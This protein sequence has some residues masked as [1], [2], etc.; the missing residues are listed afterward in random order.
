[1]DD[2]P[3]PAVPAKRPRHSLGSRPFARPHTNQPRPQSQNTPPHYLQKPASQSIYQAGTHHPPPL[4]AHP[5]PAPRPNYRPLA[6]APQQSSRPPASSTVS[7]PATVTPGSPHIDAEGMTVRPQIDSRLGI[8][9]SFDVEQPDRHPPEMLS[10]QST[11]Q[12]STQ[13]TKRLLNPA[14]SKTSNSQQ[15]RNR[16]S[17]SF[18]RDRGPT[19]ADDDNDSVESKYSLTHLGQEIFLLRPTITRM[20]QYVRSESQKL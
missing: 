12:P 18:D 16:E 15:S 8:D 4:R 5:T 11:S 6:S 20:Y 9:M 3:S 2:P 1:M 7:V 10:N 13:S 17:L 14:A 19:D